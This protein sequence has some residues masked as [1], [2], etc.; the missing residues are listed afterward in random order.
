VEVESE[1]TPG[2][3]SDLRG[4]SVAIGKTDTSVAA[5]LAV[6]TGLFVAT[7]IHWPIV[8]MEDASMLLRYSQNLA[9][10][11]GIVWNVGEAPVE[12]ATDFLYML[13]VGVTSAVTKANVK[14]AAAILLLVS[15]MM[16]V[17]VLYLG[18]RRI[19][20]ASI[21]VA[22]GFAAVLGA[23][24][25]YHYVDTAF[26]PPFYALFALLT[27]YQGLRCI[28]AGV[29]WQRA[30]RF[31]AFGFITGLI[32][33]D[34]VILTVLMLCSTLYGVKSKRSQLVVSFGVIFGILGGIYF[35]WRLHYF[36]YPLPNPF[37]IKHQNWPQPVLLK[38][39][40]RAVIEM[41]LPVL[42]LAGL[43]LRSRVAL[44][45]LIVWLITVIPFTSVWMVM[46]DDNNHFSRFQYVLVP[47]SLMAIGGIVADWW[48]DLKRSKPDAAEA[49]KTPLACGAAI[50]LVFTIF[51]NMH[52]YLQPYSNTGSQQVAMR[53]RPYAA[54]N[55]TM[56]TTEAGDIPFYSE[57]RAIDAL[58]LN[59][60]YIAHHGGVLSTEYL[61]QNHPEV[62]LYH[63][64]GVYLEPDA[65]IPEEP[66]Y[67]ESTPPKN[68][69]KL[70]SNT[71]IIRD[72]AQAHGYILAARWGAVY[73]DYHVF[74]VR[75]DFADSAAI[76]S[77]IK[78]HPYYMQMTGELAYNYRDT[79]NPPVPCAVSGR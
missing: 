17:V 69:D 4:T 35:L 22:A 77:E 39:S 78:D 18:L 3:D 30:I 1:M 59:D 29:T 9:R 76:V 56:V 13:V 21:F 71:M 46:S 32:R 2:N 79:P 6:A 5:L 62:M 34:G 41:L 25:G 57:W 51:Y 23:G 50:L 63:E 55:Y 49:V 36:G 47:I 20:A 16:S 14:T 33:P 65:F 28:Q 75:P 45:S 64:T 73:C 12:G 26:S 19:H 37:Y 7:H 44:K 67:K 60:A 40:L 15:Q 8:P 72:Y 53:L 10:G 48:S 70:T 66:T 52:L 31:G 74:W 54:K 42:P 38:L 11:H 58:G 43:A 68:V 61:E 24:L 27:W